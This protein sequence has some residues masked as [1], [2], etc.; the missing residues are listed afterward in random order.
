MFLFRKTSLR[1]DKIWGSGSYDCASRLLI[2]GN[3]SQVHQR[4]TWPVLHQPC[5]TGIVTLLHKHCYTSIVTLL[6]KH[7]YTSIVTLLH[8][9]CTMVQN[10]C[11]TT[12]ALTHQQLPPLAL[13]PELVSSSAIN[14]TISDSARPR[15]RPTNKVDPSEYQRSCEL[16]NCQRPAA[17]SWL[18]SKIA[19]EGVV[20]ICSF[21]S[22]L[23]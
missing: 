20:A 7:C 14:I 4:N 22:S 18:K 16:A 2:R 10:Q 9:H 8:K 6:H 5:Y 3:S 11:H 21:Y 19:T 23:W 1:G 13:P 17:L 15:L 12:R